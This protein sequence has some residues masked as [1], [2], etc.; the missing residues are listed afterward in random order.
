MCL[1]CVEFNKGKLSIRE[2]Y[3]NLLEMYSEEDEHSKDVWVMLVEAELD[4]E[5]NK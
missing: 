3:S 4:S 1:I 2:A 5:G